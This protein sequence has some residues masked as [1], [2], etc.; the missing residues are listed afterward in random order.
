[1]QQCRDDGRGSQESGH[2]FRLR[3]IPQ[4]IKNNY[5]G[6]LR[7]TCRNLF[8]HLLDPYEKIT[9]VDIKA[10]NQIMN[11]TIYIS[12]TINKLFECISNCIQHVDDV[13]T[14]YM[15]A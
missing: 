12:F 2:Q 15:M 8:K 10:N 4:G 9:T 7:V 1:M 11:D 14:P 5:T 13:K 3:H 6:F